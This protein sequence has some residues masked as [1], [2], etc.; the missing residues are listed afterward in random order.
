MKEKH[1]NNWGETLIKVI[2]RWKILMLVKIIFK[3]FVGN[4]GDHW[5]NFKNLMTICG[6][7]ELQFSTSF[8]NIYT[9]KYQNIYTFKK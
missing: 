7:F 5:E 6:L 8:Y 2:C 1:S 4:V 9:K 3:T